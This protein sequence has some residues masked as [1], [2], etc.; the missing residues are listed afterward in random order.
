MNYQRVKYKY[1]EKESLIFTLLGDDL[2]IYEQICQ[3]N[4]FEDASG[5]T[6]EYWVLTLQCSNDYWEVIGLNM[7]MLSMLG[8]VLPC[9]ELNLHPA[10]CLYGKF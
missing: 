10:A 8:C 7:N 9:T 3:H 6:F 1:I 5:V 4:K 2:Y